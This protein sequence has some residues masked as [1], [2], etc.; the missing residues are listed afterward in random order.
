MKDYNITGYVHIQAWIEPLNYQV[1]IDRPDYIL[2]ELYLKSF[3]Q[4]TVIKLGVP[5]VPICHCMY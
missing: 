5:V 3:G 1:Q 4:V 2:V